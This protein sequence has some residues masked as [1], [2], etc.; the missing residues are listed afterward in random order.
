MNEQKTR[1][2]AQEIARER[3][4]MESFATKHHA[5]HDRVNEFCRKCRIAR[6]EAWAREQGLIK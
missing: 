6:V 3:R 4:L 1:T 5:E 2:M